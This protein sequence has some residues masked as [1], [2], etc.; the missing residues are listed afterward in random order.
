VAS[1]GS[2]FQ[3]SGLWTAYPQNKCHNPPQCV[4]SNRVSDAAVDRAIIACFLAY[5][6]TGAVKTLKT[7]PVFEEPS[8]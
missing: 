2:S 3:I 4:Q 6:L 1:G 5:N 7:K 8:S